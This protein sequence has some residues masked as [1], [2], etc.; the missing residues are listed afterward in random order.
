MPGGS[1]SRRLCLEVF[2]IWERKFDPR[3][4]WKRFP[5]S[6]DGK[7]QDSTNSTPAVNTAPDFYGF[8]TFTTT[9]ILRKANC[10]LQKCPV[11]WSLLCLSQRAGCSTNHRHKKLRCKI[12]N[13]DSVWV[14]VNVSS[15]TKLAALS[16][17]LTYKQVTKRMRGSICLSLLLVWMDPK[18]LISSKHWNSLSAVSWDASIICLWISI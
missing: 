17:I 9:I 16:I 2:V 11:L 14:S 15:H 10:M 12:S 13:N 7:Q 6:G 18:F 5:S 3:L 1:H 8:A 4:F